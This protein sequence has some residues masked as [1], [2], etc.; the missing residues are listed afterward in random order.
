MNIAAIARKLNASVAIHEENFLL[1]F[2][3]EHF[4]SKRTAFENYFSDSLESAERN[5]DII[6]MLES[7]QNE[8]DI[9]LLNKEIR[10]LIESLEITKSNIFYQFPLNQTTGKVYELPERFKGLF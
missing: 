4:P 10:E 8:E 3:G 6:Q 2:L 1:K 7:P 5:K 9:G